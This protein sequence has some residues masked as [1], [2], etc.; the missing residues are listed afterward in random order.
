MFLKTSES[1]FHSGFVEPLGDVFKWHMA[2]CI[3]GS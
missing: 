3:V 1:V 2:D